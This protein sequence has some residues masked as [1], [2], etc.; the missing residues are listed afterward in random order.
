MEKQNKKIVSVCFVI[1]GFCL[2]LVVDV[3]MDSLA[4]SFG[5][6]ARFRSLALVS[7]GLPVLVG[8]VAFL[9]LQLNKKVLLWADEVVMEVRKV[10]WPSRRD[11][12]AMTVVTCVMLI[13]SGILL[14]VFDFFSRH[15]IKMILN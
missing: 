7:H 15:L 10:V 11:T 1:V 2:A 14:G 13:T 12:T 6:V 5:A 8:I 3:M 9:S 4:A